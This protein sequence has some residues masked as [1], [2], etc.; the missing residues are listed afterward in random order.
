[1]HSLGEILE[2]GDYSDALDTMFRRR[3]ATTA[4]DTPDI[5]QARGAARAELLGSITRVMDAQRLDALA[6]PTL[7]RKAAIIG[8]PQRRSENCQLSAST[9][10]PAIGIPAGFTDDGVPVGVELLG[11]AWSETQTAR[12]GLRLRA[13][14]PHPRRPPP[15]TPPLVNG[16]AP[17]V[18]TFVVNLAGAHVTFSFDPVA[19]S[20]AWDAVANKPLFATVHRG[21]EGP[22][23]A[24]LITSKATDAAGIVTLRTADRDALR[25]NGLFLSVR[26]MA[27]PKQVERAP[28]RVAV[29]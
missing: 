15:A 22:V 3:N 13:A 1:M 2:R 24:T 8:E 6:Y 25:A 29:P 27:A 16:R 28:L 19:G 5:A 18:L 4:P 9:G 26:T 10:L 21:R 20:L 17:A 14:R 23:L 7:R 12:D 11:P